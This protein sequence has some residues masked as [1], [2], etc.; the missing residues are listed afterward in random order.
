M[1]LCF[2]QGANVRDI[3]DVDLDVDPI[4]GLLDHFTARV[5]AARAAGVDRLVLDPG[6]GFYYGNLVDPQTRLRHQ[7]RVI[8]STFRLRRLGLPICHA[9]PHAFDTFED[10]F[11]SAEGFFAVLAML[12]GTSLLRTHEVPQVRAVVR[13]MRSLEV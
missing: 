13:A 9:L 8:A 5:A 2:V 11:R 7:S 12:G 4:P 6:M 3:R 10:Q 1:V